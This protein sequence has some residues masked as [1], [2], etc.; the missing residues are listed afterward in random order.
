MIEPGHSTIR[1]RNLAKRF[2]SKSDDIR[3]LNYVNPNQ[4]NEM[5]TYERTDDNI[6]V[7]FENV[8]SALL[9]EDV[10]HHVNYLFPYYDSRISELSVANLKIAISP[11][12][13]GKSAK[14]VKYD[15]NVAIYL[16]NYLTA[17]LYHLTAGL[18]S[19]QFVNDVKSFKGKSFDEICAVGF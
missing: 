10:L 5:G 19:T 14:S 7:E 17:L 4:M 12:N 13:D 15:R 1:L 8:I 9:S 6:P 16:S 2:L 18:A 3:Y 11:K